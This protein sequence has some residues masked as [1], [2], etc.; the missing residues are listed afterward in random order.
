MPVGQ[1]AVGLEAGDDPNPEAGLAGDGADGRGDGAGGNPGK[2]AQ[3]SP[4]VEAEGPEPFGEGKD[5]LAMGYRGEERLV[6]PEAPPGQT[7]GV[8][9]G[10][11]VARLAGEGEQVL[12]GA[13]VTANPGEAVLQEPAG[14]E[15][16]DDLGDDRAPVAV[17]R[18]EALIPD[19]AQLA[20]PPVEEPIEGRRPGPAGAIFAITTQ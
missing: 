15:L 1:R 3:Q 4:P 9:T 19:Q 7:L 10:A 5:D 18:G 8:A 14:E 11:E 2:V 16:L 13:G 12:V 17:G 6:Q 20:K